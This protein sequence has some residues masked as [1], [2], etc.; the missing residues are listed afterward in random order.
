MFEFIYSAIA[1]ACY[2]ACAVLIICFDG[3][4]RNR[5]RLHEFIAMM[6][7]AS[8]AGQSVN[9]IFL[10]DPVTIW[11]AFFGVVLFVIIFKAKGNIAFIFKGK[12]S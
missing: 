4:N 8:F 12:T 7:I 10:K 6:L 1:V 2:I 3:K 9:I 11:D 5:H